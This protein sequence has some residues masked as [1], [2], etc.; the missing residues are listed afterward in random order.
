MLASDTATNV[1]IAANRN[2]AVLYLVSYCDTAAVDQFENVP[3]DG[4]AHNTNS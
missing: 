4:I 1:R 2:S 3:G